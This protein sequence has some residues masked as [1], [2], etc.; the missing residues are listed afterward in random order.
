MV[1]SR[2]SL[3]LVLIVLGLPTV[4]SAQAAD[5]SAQAATTTQAG[6]AAA[7]EA[8]GAGTA[9]VQKKLLLYVDQ[10]SGGKFTDDRLLMISRS[11]L[12]RLQ[13]GIP[14]LSVSDTT[15]SASP[16]SAG[17]ITAI[18]QQ[19]GADYWLWTQV[20]E[21]S[22]KTTLRVQGFDLAAQEMK[23]DTTV[24]RDGEL[25]VLDLPFE[26]WGDVVALVTPSL[27]PGVVEKPSTAAS[28]QQDLT[29]TV[30][31]LPGTVLTG[32]GGKKATVG[33]DGT[34]V[35]KYPT[36]GEYPLRAT[37]SGYYPERRQVFLEAD[38]ELTIDQ[39]PASRWA[40]DASMLQVTYPSIDVTGFIFPNS[41]YVKLGITSY[42]LGLAFSSTD[43]FTSNPLT[44]I[45]LQAGIYLRPEDVIFRAYMNVGAFVRIV[46]APGSPLEIDPVSWGGIQFSIG[47]EIGRSPR[48]RFFLEFQPMLYATNFP[49]LFQAFFGTSGT[50][51]GWVFS[52]TGALNILSFRMG[53]RWML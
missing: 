34:A 27:P 29:L 17:S 36:V 53:Y 20:S 32:S 19:A 2:V 13:A 52:S 47:T 39:A 21:D 26:T 51:V 45:V 5:A 41:L 16:A 28:A 10:A 8:T 48:G 7:A 44:N 6:G 49:T 25:S 43:V 30:H 37:L 4:L 14:G 9:Q 22:G 42:A 11:L 3:V 31:A 50:P 38:R 18:A 24:S 33:N 40:I 23:V 35:L 12:I 46:N 1:A 15:G